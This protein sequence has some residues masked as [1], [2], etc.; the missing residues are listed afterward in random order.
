MCGHVL[1]EPITLTVRNISGHVTWGPHTVS[2]STLVWDLKLRLLAAADSKDLSPHALMLL[3]GASLLSNSQT[4]DVCPDTEVELTAVYSADSR[5]GSVKISRGS[6]GFIE[7]PDVAKDHPLRDVFFHQSDC[8][9]IKPCKGEEVRFHLTLDKRGNPKAVKV[10]H[11]TRAAPY[12]GAPRPA[13]LSSESLAVL[14]DCVQKQMIGEKLFP[15]IAAHQPDLAGKITGILLELDNTELLTII[16]SQQQLM[17]RMDSALI[18]LEQA[19]A[20]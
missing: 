2:P 14:P 3:N 8:D 12:N 9:D 7:S 13:R 11:A 5:R 16:E 20:A 6:W 17:S 19:Q 4:L 18:A 15:A 10:T 1:G